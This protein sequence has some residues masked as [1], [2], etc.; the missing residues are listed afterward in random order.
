MTMSNSSDHVKA[1]EQQARQKLVSEYANIASETGNKGISGYQNLPLA[2]KI[3]I[4][5]GVGASIYAAVQFLNQLSERKKRDREVL[6][7]VLPAS[8]LPKKEKAASS[9]S[10]NP[11]VNFAFNAIAP[12]ALATG[13]FFAASQLY[14]QLKKK[15]LK[16][17]REYYEELYL[18]K[19]KQIAQEKNSECKDEVSAF[20]E[21]VYDVLQEKKA[22]DLSFL[23]KTADL[24][25][26]DRFGEAARSLGLTVSEFGKK[27]SPAVSE[28]RNTGKL[29]VDSATA[30]A[31]LGILSIGAGIYGVSKYRQV[32]LEEKERRRHPLPTRVDLNIA[33]DKSAQTVPP[34]AANQDNPNHQQ[35]IMIDLASKTPPSQQLLAASRKQFSTWAAPLVDEY[36]KRIQSGAGPMV[37]FFQEGHPDSLASKVR[38]WV[39]G[40]LEGIGRSYS[41]LPVYL[42]PIGKPLGYA[43]QSAASGVD[44][45]LNHFAPQLASRDEA[46]V[47][48]HRTM[49]G[50]V[51]DI[52][53]SQKPQISAID[54]AHQQFQNSGLS[55]DPA[56]GE[57]KIQDYGKALKA[58]L[59]APGI[60][61][62]AQTLQFSPVGQA[63]TEKLVSRG[64]NL[65]RDLLRADSSNAYGKLLNQVK[66]EIRQVAEQ[67]VGDINNQIADINS[68]LVGLRK[69]HGVNISPD[70]K[71]QIN[72]L[73][74]AKNALGKAWNDLPEWGKVALGAGIPLTAGA[75]LLG[76]FS[77]RRKK[78]REGRDGNDRV[79]VINQGGPSFEKDAPNQLKIGGVLPFLMQSRVYNNALHG[80]GLDTQPM[81]PY[82]DSDHHLATPGVDD[83]YRSPRVDIHTEKND[84]Q[85]KRL[86]RNP[87]YRAYIAELIA[88]ADRQATEQY[89]DS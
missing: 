80:V 11:V 76:A 49:Q 17:D 88:E 59:N 1:L 70:G 37:G 51:D 79:V 41:N 69:Q 26:T 64:E 38:D 54:S 83:Y 89:G 25:A 84:A 68:N 87:K 21:G 56:T 40:A 31:L 29:V 15:Q 43:Y 47:K 7:V 22:E 12:A 65:W 45:L 20:W 9:I 13:G 52:L 61:A 2:Q 32:D 5:T 48:M 35:S 3:L 34:P 60:S 50:V 28:A 4:P 53:S 66:P 67:T 18:D 33:L 85:L 27:I 46:E 36:Q 19:L 71:I 58:Y 6:R 44:R 16:K 62:D 75:L 10:D 14:E 30:A 42:A 8:K 39:P 57:I 23:P 81:I 82:S 78:Q 77:N 24:S 86:L 63:E 72:K 73:Y 55:I 74:V